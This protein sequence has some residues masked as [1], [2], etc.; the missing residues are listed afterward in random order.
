MLEALEREAPFPGAARIGI[1]GPPGAGKS[2]LLDALI[3]SLRRRGETVA[4][5]AVDPSSRRTGG[6]LLGDRIRMRTGSRDPGVL[7]RSMAARRR[8]GGLAD[9]TFAGVAVL[10]A[11]F[12]RVFVETVGVGQSES[13]VASLVDTLVFVASPGS[14]DALQFM[15]AGLLELPDVFAVNKADVGAEASRTA[16]ELAGGLALAEPESRTGRRPV[17]LVSARDA[18]GIEELVDAIDEHA[19]EQLERGALATRRASAREEFVLE[20]LVQRYGSFGLEHL[21]GPRAV[22]DRI[23]EGAGDSAFALAAALSR[24]IE[25]AL[26]KPA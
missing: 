13:E 24:E 4:L 9:S 17:L 26:R 5:I 1:T 22:A 25:D 16:S 6:A 20:T 2:T 8:L 14:G 11:V 15:K 10:S 7:I 18:V 21:G 12:D 19:R 3:R 23:R